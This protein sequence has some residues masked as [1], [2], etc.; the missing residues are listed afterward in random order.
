MPHGRAMTP[1]ANWHQT[2]FC[3]PASTNAEIRKFEPKRR[4][5]NDTP[6]VLSTTG[7]PPKHL[8]IPEIQTETRNMHH[9]RAI[10]KAYLDC[11]TARFSRIMAEDNFSAT[12][13]LQSCRFCRATFCSASA[14][15]RIP[16]ARARHGRTW[17]RV[18][19]KGK[20]KFVRLFHIS[21]KLFLR[22]CSG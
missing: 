6:A 8:E 12:A 2:C 4:R 1:N 11:P 18:E 20:G 22:I 21:P 13:N 15:F 3:Q 7:R 5:K 14:A 10:A 16:M 19:G 17:R 9:H